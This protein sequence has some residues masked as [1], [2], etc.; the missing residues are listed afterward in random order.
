MAGEAFVP[1]AFN[2]SAGQ[3]ESASA[4]STLFDANYLFGGEQAIATAGSAPS[5]SDQRAHTEAPDPW[6]DGSPANVLPAVPMADPNGRWFPWDGS[7]PLTVSLPDGKDV[8]TLW[9]PTSLGLVQIF[10]G[11]TEGGTPLYTSNA[12]A[13]CAPIPSGNKTLTLVAPNGAFGSQMAVYATNDVLAPSRLA[14]PPVTSATDTPT[15]VVQSAGTNRY[16]LYT[17]PISIATG[18]GASTYF[19]LTVPLNAKDIELVLLFG[20]GGPWD[21]TVNMGS[22]SVATPAAATLV[23]Q[24]A[25]GS[26]IVDNP[27]GNVL[28]TALDGLAKSLLLSKRIPGSGVAV[29]SA[30]I[31]TNGY[32]IGSYLV[33]ASSILLQVQ[34]NETGAGNTTVQAAAAF[35]A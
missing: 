15:S 22:Q 23:N 14:S 33:E 24:S 4:T 2:A 27:V 11:L 6:Y 1:E 28:Y 5:P 12:L 9:F 35:S 29:G 31:G 26:W 32:Q 19:V 30:T 7:K 8:R 21:V 20:S 3:K 25:I 10:S 16:T 17:A 18:V 34:C 13:E